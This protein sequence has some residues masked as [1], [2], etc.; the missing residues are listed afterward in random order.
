MNEDKST[1]YHR[2]R[3]RAD[4]LG[5]AAAG[6]VLLGLAV[7]GGAHRLREISAAVSQWV[8]GG[9]DDAMNVAVMTLLVVLILQAIEFPFAFYQGHLLEHRYGLSTQ[10]AAR[11][12]SD[13]GKG[14]VVGVVLAVA[15]TSVMG[16]TVGRSRGARRGGRELG[17]DDAMEKPFDPADLTARV[18]ALIGEGI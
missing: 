9:I 14:V 4:L 17:A 16:P 13:Q 6:L 5:T 7:G 11:W 2:L 12:L 8:P 1:R 3:R 15:A 18:R 10:S